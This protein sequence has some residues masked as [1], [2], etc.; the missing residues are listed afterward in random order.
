MNQQTSRTANERLGEIV[1]ERAGGRPIPFLCECADMTCH[2]RIEMT[3][4]DFD[5][6]HAIRTHYVILPGHAM[7][8]GEA[9]LDSSPDGYLIVQK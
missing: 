6:I 7:A 2:G 4:R 3:V 8:D 9:V 1:E 5:A